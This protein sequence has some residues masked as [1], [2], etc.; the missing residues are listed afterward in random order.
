MLPE[1]NNVLKYTNTYVL[2]RYTKDYPNNSLTAEEALRELLKYFWLS[3]KYSM[4][5]QLDPNNKS[6]H[7]FCAMHEEMKEIDDMWHTFL[8]FTK[9]YMSFCNYYFNK[10]IHHEPLMN[11]NQPTDEDFEIDLTRYLSY[12][13]D[14]LGEETVRA[15]FKEYS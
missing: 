8:L 14:Q 13:Y 15:W 9:E 12:V 5:L 10:F 6:L 3:E 4:D 1:L 7:F 2:E 11:A